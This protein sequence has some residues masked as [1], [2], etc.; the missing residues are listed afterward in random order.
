MP[1]ISCTQD[2][3]SVLSSQALGPGSGITFTSCQARCCDGDL[4]NDGL[5]EILTTHSPETVTVTGK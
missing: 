2:L 4:C 5:L 3:C 1:A